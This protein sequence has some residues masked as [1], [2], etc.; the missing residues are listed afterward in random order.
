MPDC[1]FNDTPKIR[2]A[3]SLFQINP[4]P[5]KNKRPVEITNFHLARTK[6]T[7]KN[8][9]ATRRTTQQFSTYQQ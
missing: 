4:H 8:P 3:I 5:V 7:H 2:K 9:F 6:T 1:L